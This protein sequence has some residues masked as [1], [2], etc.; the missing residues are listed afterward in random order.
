MNDFAQQN[1]D[2][3]DRM[4]KLAGRSAPESA[5]VQRA[6][7]SE[8]E[9]DVTY[10]YDVEQCSEEWFALRCGILTASTMK[11]VITPAKL[12]R[13]D[14]ATSRSHVYELVAQRIAGYVDVSD[15]MSDDMER[16]YL[17]EHDAR[18]LYSKHFAP[19]RQCG[20]ISNDKWGFRIGY[21]PD[22]LVG[23]DGLI[24]AKG[25][26]HKHHVETILTNEM[27]ADYLMQVQTAML[28]TGRQWCDFISY[29]AGLPM[30][31]IRVY[32]EKAVQE[33][34]L[35]AAYTIE[36][37]IEKA[38]ETYADRLAATGAR[39]IETK[40]RAPEQDIIVSETG[41]LGLTLEDLSL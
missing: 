21:S 7:L 38:L 2:V 22:G 19:V 20:F 37:E 28:V 5:T 15:F 17:D 8:R 11:H 24:E 26:R 32:P 30:A 16:G 4:Y 18:E 35:D 29:S 14:N 6:H 27:P 33:A 13:A 40:R 9:G 1:R 12:K 36:A 23:K 31:V 25:R 41:P 3:L 34:I 39:F 10:H